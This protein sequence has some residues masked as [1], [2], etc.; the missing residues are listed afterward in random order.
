ML[1]GFRPNFVALLKWGRGRVRSGLP[2]RPPALSTRSAWT[3]HRRENG[4]YEGASSRPGRMLI[5]RW[6]L[7]R[8]VLDP[9]PVAGAGAIRAG[10]GPRGLQPA[11]TRAGPNSAS[12]ASARWRSELGGS[13]SR[14]LA[15]SAGSRCQVAL[16]HHGESALGRCRAKASGEQTSSNAGRRVL[17]RKD[18]RQV[19]RACW[20][21]GVL[22]R[23]VSLQQ[24]MATVVAILPCIN[25]PLSVGHQNIRQRSKGGCRCEVT[26][27]RHCR[28]PTVAIT[29][30][31]LLKAD[32]LQ[33]S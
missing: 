12:S 2:A 17:A 3:E 20:C 26:L 15:A 13:S 11:M 28:K 24:L 25:L 6:R 1:A 23:G 10:P 30:E 18:G 21:A 29:I 16:P 9:G 22:V 27:K 19:D 5:I 32:E 31:R 7:P 4:P 8:V 14:S 33:R